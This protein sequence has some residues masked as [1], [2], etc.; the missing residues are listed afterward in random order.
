L[1]ANRPNE[2]SC[3]D[4]GGALAALESTIPPRA[5]TVPVA[6]LEP[7]RLG[8][9]RGAPA[10]GVGKPFGGWMTAPGGR[11][12]GFAFIIANTFGAWNASNARRRTPP[13]AR[14]IFCFFTLAF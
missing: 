14:M 6:P 13:T 10:G 2:T 8:A 4:A 12:G 3:P 5:A 9:A 7:A 11:G 1:L